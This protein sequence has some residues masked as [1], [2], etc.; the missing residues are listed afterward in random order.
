MSQQHPLL[1]ARDPALLAQVVL[2]RL[3]APAY[4]EE[5]SRCCATDGR[6]HRS[7]GVWLNF[8]THGCGR[9]ETSF[10]E[11]A[12][13]RS[14]KLTPMVRFPYLYQPNWNQKHPK[15]L[16]LGLTSEEGTSKK[17]GETIALSFGFQASHAL[18]HGAQLHSAAFESWID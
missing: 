13:V 6:F 4:L 18:A 7:P 1:C 8:A 10:R 3:W 14:F 5:V 11:A 17:P 16:L 9:A 15:A 12:E 2:A